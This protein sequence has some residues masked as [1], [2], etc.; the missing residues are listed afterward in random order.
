MVN[1]VVNTFQFSFIFLRAVLCYLLK[2]LFDTQMKA[3]A[4]LATLIKALATNEKKMRQRPALSL[5]VRFRKK[6]TRSHL[7]LCNRRVYN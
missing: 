4:M 7:V 3:N 5:Q 1:G 2:I 6:S